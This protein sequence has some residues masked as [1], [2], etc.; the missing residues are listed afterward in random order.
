V[1]CEHATKV[2][3]GLSAVCARVREL[4]A[5]V[6]VRV[7]ARA[8]VCAVI[9]GSVLHGVSQGQLSVLPCACKS[10]S[11]AVVWLLTRHFC[12]TTDIECHFLLTKL[13]RAEPIN[14]HGQS[15]HVQVL[16]L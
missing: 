9:H 3:E 10:D 13:S 8:C 12:C 1:R 16:G 2:S 5:R 4:C 7:R 11:I 15:K 6:R 14:T